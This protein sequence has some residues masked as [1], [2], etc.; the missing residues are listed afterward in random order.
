MNVLEGGGSKG[1]HKVNSTDL[2]GH[3]RTSP[4]E[5]EFGTYMVCL[6]VYQAVLLFR[7][8]STRQAPHSGV[9]SSGAGE[10]SVTD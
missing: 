4:V 10:Y 6:V 2:T 9:M 5:P 3:V 8:A 7:D 1:F